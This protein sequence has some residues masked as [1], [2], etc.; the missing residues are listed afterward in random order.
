MGGGGLYAWLALS[1]LTLLLVD[2]Q[3]ILGDWSLIMNVCK[4]PAAKM[5]KATLNR[6][7]NFV[8]FRNCLPTG[9][10]CYR[11]WVFPVSNGKE[12]II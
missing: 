1:G 10:H 11:E 12:C 7:Q 5:W 6:V 3:S 2:G 8:T 4:S 9:M